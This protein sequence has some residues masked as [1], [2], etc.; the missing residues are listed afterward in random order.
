MLRSHYLVLLHAHLARKSSVRHPL[1][2]L[3]GSDLTHHLINL[4]QA[5]AL[6]LWN[7]KVRESQ[8][9]STS[10]SPHE[11][12]LRTKI[13]LVLVDHVGSDV[14]NDKV[15]KPIRGCR[16]RHSLCTDGKWE[17]FSDNGPG[18]RAPGRGEEGDVDAY[19]HNEDVAG[20]AGV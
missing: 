14:A 7:Q 17:D 20:G 4:L 18:A 1:S 15:P 10:A 9:G 3:P 16:E 6:R 19:E 8:A 2:T 11:E 5:Q 12:N 13:A